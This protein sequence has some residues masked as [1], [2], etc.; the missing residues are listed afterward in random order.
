G[1][2][3]M[4]SDVYEL[5]FKRQV[6][7]SVSMDLGY[8]YFT[9]HSGEITDSDHFFRFQL[10]GGHVNHGGQIA[11][12]YLSGHYVPYPKRHDPPA[13]ILDLTY[14]RRWPASD[15]RL[16]LSFSREEAPELSAGIEDNFEAEVK[17]ETVF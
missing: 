9:P 14:E 7:G 13:S 8:R 17:Y 5:A 4:L 3:V 1:K 2:S 10:D 16:M 15:G 11:L 6:M 12:K